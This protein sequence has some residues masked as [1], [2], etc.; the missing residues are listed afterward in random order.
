MLLDEN[1]RDV[2]RDEFNATM[3]ALSALQDAYLALLRQ[4]YRMQARVVKVGEERPAVRVE[5]KQ[6][7]ELKAVRIVFGVGCLPVNRWFRRNTSFSAALDADY[8]MQVLWIELA[9]EAARQL[10]GV[11]FEKAAMMVRFIVRT[12]ADADAF[13]YVLKYVVDGLR[14]AG[15]L[16]S[17]ACDALLRLVEVEI[18]KPE[19]VEVLLWDLENCPWAAQARLDRDRLAQG[20]GEP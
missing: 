13:D 18:G 9:Q 20:L 17:D 15:I 2:W 5:A 4:L 7:P 3:H 10:N 6:D 14:A 12:R 16:V 1:G 11:C 19:R 8:Q